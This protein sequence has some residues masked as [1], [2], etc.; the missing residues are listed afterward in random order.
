MM[1]HRTFGLA[2]L[3][4]LVGCQAVFAAGTLKPVALPSS[5]GTIAGMGFSPDS[6]LIAILRYAIDRG[7]SNAKYTIQT[8]DLKTGHELF[9]SDLPSGESTY[10]AMNAHFVMFSHDGRYVLVTTAGTDVLLILDASRLQVVDRIVLHP[11]A[12]HR[13][14]LSGE[15][16]RKFQGVVSLSVASNSQ[17]FGVLTHDEELGVNE[18]FIGT[19]PSGRIIG[20]WV[21]G[22]GRTQTEMGQTSLSLSEDG[23]RVVVSVVPSGQ[24]SSSKDFKNLRLYKSENGELIRAI[25]TDGLVGQIALMPGDSVLASRIDTP[26]LFSKK[27]CIEKWNLATGILTSRFCDQ[28]RQVILLGVSQ[29]TDLLAGFAC[30]IHKDL[31]GNIFSVP[32]RIDVWDMKMG[33]LVA[34]S[35]E[36]PRLVFADIQ[37][38]PDGSWLSA[39]QMLFRIKMSN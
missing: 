20:S 12:Q 37:I 26:N 15:G 22:Y 33:V 39:N 1:R 28:G 30:R 19:F 10:L 2:A 3:A 9:Q 11:N 21:L 27:L 32:G 8:V 7:T 38:S 4:L 36:V 5:D 16:N 25:R 23:L 24:D 14:P 35:E 17:V 34:Q 13:R 6:S 18:I 29:S 31:E